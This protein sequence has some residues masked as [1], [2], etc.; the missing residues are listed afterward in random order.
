MRFFWS[1]FFASYIFLF[2]HYFF[3]KCI[4]LRKVFPCEKYFLEK[5]I[6][7][8]K[9]FPWK[10]YFLALRMYL[11]FSHGM[12]RFFAFSSLNLNLAD[13]RSDLIFFST[14][15]SI[16]FYSFQFFFPSNFFSF[17][18][19]FLLFKNLLF[20][21]ISLLISYWTGKASKSLHPPWNYRLDL[22]NT[23]MSNFV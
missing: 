13:K 12:F 23:S 8:K 21:G 18:I 2:V 17:Q 9:V 3:K 15:H 22:K 7:L 14:S 10:K 1:G 5:C 6:S 11:I 4:Y 19:L 16:F 20:F